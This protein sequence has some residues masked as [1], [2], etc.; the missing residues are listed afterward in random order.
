MVMVRLAFRF[1][2]L[3]KKTFVPEKNGLRVYPRHAC[4]HKDTSEVKNDILIINFI[5]SRTPV[6]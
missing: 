6:I 2:D 5:I 3:E 1:N 4:I